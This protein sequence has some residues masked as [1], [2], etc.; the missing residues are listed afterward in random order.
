MRFQTALLIAAATAFAYAQVSDVEDPLANDLADVLSDVEPEFPEM[1]EMAAAQEAQSDDETNVEANAAET[2]NDAPYE[3]AEDADDLA[4][5]VDA[6]EG[7]DDYDAAL[8]TDG[9]FSDDYEEAAGVDQFDAADAAADAEASD[10]E[11]ETTSNTSAIAAG[12]AG[13]TAAAA[14]I[15]LWAKKSKKFDITNETKPKNP[16]NVEAYR[17]SVM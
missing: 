4:D 1:A 14:G 6:A 16:I 15:F 11:D 12:V 2:V 17:C 9:E 13:A 5:D 7:S 8:A 10:V 3:N